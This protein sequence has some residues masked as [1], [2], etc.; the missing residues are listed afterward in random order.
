M[1]QDRIGQLIAAGHT[2]EAAEAVLSLDPDDA[3][4]VLIQTAKKLGAD[5]VP[6]LRALDQ[7]SNPKAVVK[8]ARRALHRLRS[9]GIVIPEVAPPPAEMGLIGGRRIL[10]SLLSS[11]DGSG[12]QLLTVLFSAPMT[13]TEGVDLLVSDLRGV[14]DMHVIRL[15]KREYD[16]GIIKMQ[17]EFTII[18]APVDYV[19]FRAREYEEINRRQGLPIPSDYHIYRQLFYMP[20]REYD[21]PIIYEELDEADRSLAN[22]AKEVFETRDFRTWLIEDEIQPFVS[23]IIEAE[24]SPIVLSDAAKEERVE[25]VIRNAAETIFTPEVRA[26][27]QRRLEENAY[28]LLHTDQADLAKVALACAIELV[29]DGPPS[30]QVTFVQ[31]IIKYSV[32]VS[33]AVQERESRIHRIGS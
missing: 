15:A 32:S 16:E 21:R 5:A 9:Q 24:E 3:E 1:D 26:R 10:R 29:P 19:L 31:E 17:E 8:S 6:L 11:V 2:D 13:G 7:P 18:D 27:Y 25:R 14:Y 28:V 30:P 33:I 20:G 22:R 23:Q 4:Q 12:T